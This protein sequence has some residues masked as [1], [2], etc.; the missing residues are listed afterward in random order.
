[1]EELKTEISRLSDKIKQIEEEL[2]TVKM[3]VRELVM[4]VGIGIGVMLI[5]FLA[6]LT[7]E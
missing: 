7:R 4:M 1:M 2:K 3:K 5:Y 6:H